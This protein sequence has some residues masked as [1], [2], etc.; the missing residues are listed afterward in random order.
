MAGG[1]TNAKDSEGYVG[2]KRTNPL[3]VLHMHTCES[4]ILIL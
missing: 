1:Q 2:S 4:A 3:E